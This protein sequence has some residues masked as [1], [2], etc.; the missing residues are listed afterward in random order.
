MGR[1]IFGRKEKKRYNLYKKRDGNM[2][3]R[4]AKKVQKKIKGKELNS[5]RR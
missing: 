5:G 2:C 4:I 3:R 1:K